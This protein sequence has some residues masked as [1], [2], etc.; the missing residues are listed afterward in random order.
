MPFDNALKRMTV[1]YDRISDGKR[2][3]FI[4]GG[5]EA[6]T[7]RC[8]AYHASQSLQTTP[9]DD[10]FWKT[11]RDKTEEYGKQG[12]RVLALGYKVMEN[13]GENIT[14]DNR[15]EVEK[16]F[17]FVGLIG[18][19][20][21]PR[22]ESK[23]AVR[24][25]HIAG[26]DVHMVT[27]D[28]VATAETIAKQIGIISPEADPAFI[29]TAAE[30]DAMSDKELDELE[31]FPLVIAR[32]A[33][34]T[35]VKIVNALH[36]K[37]KYCA[38]TGDG[39]NDAPALKKAHVGFAMGLSGSDVA[40]QA[41]DI[42]LTDDNFS[43]IV[44][45][46]AE[47]RRIFT[48]IVKLSKHLLTTNV[49]EVVLLIIGLALRDSNGEAIYPM[50]PIQI[51]WLNMLTSS[52]IAISLGMED[53]DVND[54][55]REPP[56]SKDAG[57]ISKDFL[58]DTLVYG[59]WAGILALGTFMISL[60]V[61]ANYFSAGTFLTQCNKYNEAT[62]GQC[63]G[64]FVARAVSF[65]TLVLIFLI[66]GYIVRHPVRS[67]FHEL[68]NPIRDARA[69]DPFYDPALDSAM[70]KPRNRGLLVS[71]FIG[72]LL[73]IPTSY[74]PGLNLNLLSQGVITWQWGLI[75]PAQILFVAGAEMF[76]L[77]KRRK[78]PSTT[79]YGVA[80]NRVLTMPKNAQSLLSLA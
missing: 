34:E 55:L 80:L 18:I 9:V 2:V 50:S 63:E 33:P 4:K 12:M 22:K 71:V 79:Y 10:D 41:S 23:D 3:A 40:K 17:V 31:H 24:C 51:L 6:V 25:C 20:D 30:L 46:I 15:D 49:A 59:T 76:K 32:C 8:T 68:R 28:F 69:L 72:L 47:G 77:Y 7:K 54:L 60:A 29:K 5:L 11:I 62:Y 67:I 56:R 21:P 53:V 61:D 16:E 42:I 74:I 26:I 14:L 45:A 64:V 43:T 73:T 65:Y 57:V 19:K 37:G 70:P 13:N 35:K 39:T 75:I 36:R 27:G 52:P 1:I 78:N 58:I 48:N 38:M 66:Y 44:K